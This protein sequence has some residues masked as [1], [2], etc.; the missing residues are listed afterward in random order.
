MLTLFMYN[1]F[2]PNYSW[3]MKMHR[4]KLFVSSITLLSA[5]VFSGSVV[6]QKSGQSIQ[7][8]YGVVVASKYVQE[9]SNAGKGALVGGAVGLYAGKGKSSGTKF[10]RTAA[11][12]AVGGAAASSAQGSR[13]AREYQVRTATGVIVIISDQREIRV[14]DCVIVE[15]PSSGNANIRRVAYTYCEPASAEVVADLHDEA[16]EEAEECVMAKRELA[17][18]ADDAAVD[19]ALRKISILCDT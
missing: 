6:A 13:E 5:F 2:Q 14:D 16:L 9:Q 18:A 15:N 11:G 3:W 1:F 12:A 10:R 19:R 8:Q 7:I 17:S 4:S